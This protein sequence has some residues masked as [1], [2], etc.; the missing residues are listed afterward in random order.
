[1]VFTRNTFS[2]CKIYLTKAIWKYSV[3]DAL[4]IRKILRKISVRDHNIFSSLQEN[5]NSRPHNIHVFLC[6]YSIF[7]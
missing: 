7:I 3:I 2:L 6:T 5:W 4:K 1:M